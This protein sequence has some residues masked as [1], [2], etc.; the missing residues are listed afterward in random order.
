MPFHNLTPDTLYYIPVDGSLL[1]AEQG[2]MNYEK[3][4]PG[5]LLAFFD[6]L[7]FVTQDLDQTEL[8]VAYIRTIH[9]ICSEA[10]YRGAQDKRGQYLSNPIH[11]I[12]IGASDC[13]EAGLLEHLD[14]IE[15]H[16]LK[17]K[18]EWI[19]DNRPLEGLELYDIDVAGALS[20]DGVRYGA[21]TL[22]ETK[23]QLGCKDN[24]ELAKVFFNKIKESKYCELVLCP[25]ADKLM[26]DFITIVDDY[27][28]GILHADT[29][30]EKLALIIKTIRQAER[31]H[32]FN[33]HN[34]RTL[35]NLLLTR[36]LL[37]NG[38]DAPVIF[39][40]PNV[41]DMH[42]YDELAAIVIASIKNGERLANG[43]R[44]FQFD[45][46]TVSATDQARFRVIFDRFK[47]D[48]TP[49]QQQQNNAFLKTFTYEET[50]K[51]FVQKL[52]KYLER[53]CQQNPSLEAEIMSNSVWTEIRSILEAV[54]NAYFHDKN[55]TEARAAL[56]KLLETLPVLQESATAK[57]ITSEEGL[58][59]LYNEI[60]AFYEALADYS[61]NEET[62]TTGVATSPI[63]QP[64]TTT[65]ASDEYVR[66]RRE[67]QVPGNDE[68]LV[69]TV[70]D[71]LTS[72]SMLTR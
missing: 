63:S 17:I 9:A 31:L 16:Y 25:F 44:I 32:P 59:I 3:R 39:Y 7:Q 29:Q 46:A 41:F 37:Q 56:K 72:A 20:I 14:E 47:A 70:S 34:N 50:L 65:A 6:A 12:H 28:Q 52:G 15:K 42:S 58:V 45:P 33:D 24:A 21:S 11:R 35:V 51:M 22:A 55:I 67:Q 69:T 66:I 2:W 57:I 10:A 48:I 4:E 43:E 1:E 60:Q 62:K 36:L 53:L 23:Q 68:A 5:C 71:P 30:E 40:R 49:E 8:T 61:L 13:S 54:L 38:F 19:E 26:F 27:N 18:E 64:C